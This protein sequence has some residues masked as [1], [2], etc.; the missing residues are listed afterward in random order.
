MQSESSEFDV[1]GVSA[2]NCDRSVQRGAEGNESQVELNVHRACIHF[3]C[4][5][6]QN[7]HIRGHVVPAYA[8][9]G[10]AERVVENGDDRF[11]AV[12]A[13]FEVFATSCNQ[14]ECGQEA[15]QVKLLHWVLVLGKVTRCYKVAFECQSVACQS[16]KLE[17]LFL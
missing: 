9:V 8:D 7:A 4:L 16:K 3:Y 13:C 2:R 11:V 6:A 12:V 14:D 17:A 5:R 15:K 1:D 10:C